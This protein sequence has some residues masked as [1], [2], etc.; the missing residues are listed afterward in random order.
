M[1]T[2]RI[3]I[4]DLSVRC[5]IGVSDEERR[6][7]QD[8]LINIELVSDLSRPARTDRLEDAVDYRTLKKRLVAFV[9][10][11]SFH[12]VEALAEKIAGICL[13]DTLVQEVRVKVEKPGALR[14]ARSVG[15]EISRKRE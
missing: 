7:A 9:Q 12:L 4:R 6:D 1:R 5:V 10:G 15:V 11:S 2:D 13:E 8:V 14:F 3:I